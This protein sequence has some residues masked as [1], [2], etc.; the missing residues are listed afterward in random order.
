MQILYRSLNELNT[1]DL[2]CREDLGFVQDTVLGIRLYSTNKQLV[3][4][5]FIG[6]VQQEVPCHAAFDN[7][8]TFL[9]L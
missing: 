7:S 1:S 4:H 8:I 6:S 2:N 9:Q 5:A 3:K